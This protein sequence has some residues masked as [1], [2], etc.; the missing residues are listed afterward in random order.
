[1][2]LAFMESLLEDCREEELHRIVDTSG[3]VPFDS[4]E[5]IL[6]KVNLFFYD[7]KVMDE[8]LHKKTTGVS[9]HLILENLQKLDK[10]GA[11]IQIRI[12][13]IPGVNDTRENTRKTAEFLTNLKHI[14]M[15]NLL[16]YHRAAAQKYRSLGKI[17]K[18]PVIKAPTGESVRKI[19]TEL[20]SFG[21]TVQIGG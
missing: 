9:N 16:P 4:F 12:P 14:K 18:Y 13:V 11:V 6:D 3:Y 2:Q 1:M 10:T 17:F 19:K 8:A 5:R 20:E 21:F 7:L 15:V